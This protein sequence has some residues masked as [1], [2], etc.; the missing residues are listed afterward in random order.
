MPIPVYTTTTDLITGHVALHARRV[1]AGKLTGGP[2]IPVY[3]V[4]QAEID[5]GSFSLEGGHPINVM[6]TDDIARDMAIAG[7]HAIPIFLL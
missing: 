3:V 7:G 2:A 5:S 6:Y 1:T 4:S